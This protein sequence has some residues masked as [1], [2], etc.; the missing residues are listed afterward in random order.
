MRHLHKRAIACTDGAA[1]V[2]ANKDTDHGADGR[3]YLNPDN[4]TVTGALLHTF[5]K[6]NV[7]AHCAANIFA[8]QDADVFAHFSAVERTHARSD[9]GAVER[10]LA[11]ADGGAVNEAQRGTLACTDV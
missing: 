9:G 8:D 11:G 1:V 6:S 4:R 5:A 10:T 7:H 3:S 2:R